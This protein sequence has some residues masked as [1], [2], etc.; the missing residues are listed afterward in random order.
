MSS[1]FTP[2]PE[3]FIESFLNSVPKIKS[4]PTF[5]TLNIVRNLLKEN[6]TSV[7]SNRGGGKN[8]YLSMVLS[9]YLYAHIDPSPFAIPIYPG[10]Q[11]AIAPGAS[12]A[13]IHETVPLHSK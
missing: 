6:A 3:A 4:T 7:P 1:S 5:D 11:S 12:A 13:I 10:A 8:G 9:D 2:S